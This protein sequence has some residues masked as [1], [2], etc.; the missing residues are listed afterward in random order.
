[1]FVVGKRNVNFTST[2]E[3]TVPK[4]KNEKM[5]LKRD[6]YHK[7]VYNNDSR[8]ANIGLFIKMGQQTLPVKVNFTGN[9]Y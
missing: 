4:F 1:M 8:L 6:L 2:I 5:S 7:E 9:F 3:R